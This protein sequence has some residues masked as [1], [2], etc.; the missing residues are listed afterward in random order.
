MPPD[1]DIDYPGWIGAF[2][3][4]PGGTATLTQAPD[5]FVPDWIPPPA[6]SRLGNTD[7]TR[8]RPSRTAC[9]ADSAL[10]AGGW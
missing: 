2:S 10:I 7:S 5:F 1:N 3:V 9:E 4:G 6:G 8:T